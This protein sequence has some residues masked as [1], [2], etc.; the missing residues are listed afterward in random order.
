MGYS[1]NL[2]DAQ[3][4]LTDG[5]ADKTKPAYVSI[6]SENKSGLYLHGERQWKSNS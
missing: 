2:K 6:Q 4:V 5:K 1:G 3:W